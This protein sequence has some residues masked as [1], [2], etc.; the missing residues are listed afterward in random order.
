MQTFNLE[1]VLSAGFER[2]F[3]WECSLYLIKDVASVLYAGQSKYPA[4]RVREHVYSRDPIGLHIIAN[5]PVS[6][7]WSV[8]FL[9]LTDFGL[10]TDRWAKNF[11]DELN[12]LER[13]LIREHQPPFNSARS[14]NNRF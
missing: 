6:L 7:S 2:R 14:R 5:R 1:E 12:R 11:R 10:T 9:A 4:I 3:R 8:D 13:K